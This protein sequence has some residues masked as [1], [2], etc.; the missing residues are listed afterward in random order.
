MQVWRNPSLLVD[1]VYCSPTLF[2]V[3]QPLVGQ[4]LIITKASWSN[5]IRQITLCGTPLDEW[6]ADVGTSLPANTTL[7]RERHP[8]PRPDSKPQC[9]RANGRTLTP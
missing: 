3:R 8:C 4:G 6:S 7:T 2:I 1:V 5:S 9:Q